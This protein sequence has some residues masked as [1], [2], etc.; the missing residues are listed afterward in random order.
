MIMMLM[1]FRFEPGSDNTHLCKPT[2]VAVMSNGEFFV[3]DGYCNTRVIK[4][5]ADGKI[6]FQFGKPTP[7]NFI[8]KGI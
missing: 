8:G 5:S 2:G 1:I 6:L 3:S 7:R 4:Y